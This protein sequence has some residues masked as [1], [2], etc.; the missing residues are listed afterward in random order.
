[1]LVVAGPSMATEDRRL[2][3]AFVSQLRLAQQTLRL[4][5]DALQA[6]ALAEANNVREALL[7]AVSHD[8]RGPLANIKA[9]A[10]SLLSTDVEW[11]PDTVLAFCRSI[12]AETDRLDAVIKNLL[13][14]GRVQSGMLGVRWQPV[15]V[16]EVVY[17]ALASLAVDISIVDVDIPP[18]VPPAHADPALLERAVANVILNAINWSPRGCRVRVE[19]GVAARHVLIRVVDRG[20]G[21]PRDQREAVFRPFQRLGDGGRAGDDGIGLGLAVTK[22]FIDAM[23]GEVTIDDTPGGGATVVLTLRVAA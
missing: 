12:D 6:E 13:D 11:P 17:A 19:A 23:D 22:G 15:V 2:L 21:I 8:L 14:M 4:Q 18:D 3:S 1:M 16:E 7:A 9:S 20:A 10:T 5:A